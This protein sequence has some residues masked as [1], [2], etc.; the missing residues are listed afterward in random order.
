MKTLNLRQAIIQRVQD[1]S[2]EELLEVINGSIGSDERALPG[3]GVLFEIIWEHIDDQQQQDLVS[4]L[5]KS[6]M[7]ETRV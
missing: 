7:L 3:L 1:K 4:V 5:N 6:L 2:T